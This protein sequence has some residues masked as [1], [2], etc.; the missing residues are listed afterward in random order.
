MTLLTEVFPVTVLH[1]QPQLVLDVRAWQGQPVL[2]DLLEFL[3]NSALVLLFSS[4]PPSLFLSDRN[5]R[6][7]A[8]FIYR[9]NSRQFSS[10]G[11]NRLPTSVVVVVTFIIIVFTILN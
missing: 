4:L 7:F 3:L 11:S 10:E 2:P 9:V 5:A 8:R 6:M 1:P